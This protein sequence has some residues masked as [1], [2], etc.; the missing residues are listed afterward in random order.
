MKINQEYYLWWSS[1]PPTAKIINQIVQFT[2]ARHNFVPDVCF[3]NAEQFAAVD[4]SGVEIKVLPDTFILKNNYAIGKE[5]E[6]IR[7]NKWMDT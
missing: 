4:L 3:I 1:E 6:P 5:N 7:Q 2:Q